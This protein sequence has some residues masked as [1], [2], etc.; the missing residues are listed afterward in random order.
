MGRKRKTRAGR[1]KAA[2][3]LKITR[4]VVGRASPQGIRVPV[5]KLHYAGINKDS[6]RLTVGQLAVLL[7]CLHQCSI[8]SN[9]GYLD[10]EYDISY[11]MSNVFNK[12][13]ALNK[14]DL[15]RL[16]WAGNLA[17]SNGFF[18][19]PDGRSFAEFIRPLL[20]DGE[21]FDRGWNLILDVN[22]ARKFRDK[23]RFIRKMLTRRYTKKE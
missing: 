19:S 2:P 22:G 16:L 23:R 18:W 13:V 20:F 11:M 10:A 9:M 3:G 8:D 14:L 5:P 4:P 12:T 6:R 7:W 17:D 15:E 1:P 21:A